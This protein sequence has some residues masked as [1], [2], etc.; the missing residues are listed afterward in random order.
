MQNSLSVP[1]YL[2]RMTTIRRVCGRVH[3]VRKRNRQNSLSM[4]VYAKNK[5]PEICRNLLPHASCELYVLAV[6]N[7]FKRQPRHVYTYG[8]VRNGSVIIQKINKK[9]KQQQRQA[10]GFEN[11]LAVATYLP[12]V[13]LAD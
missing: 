8:V 3:M 10:G 1:C 4:G 11:I 6:H 9:K 5:T 12:T 2:R 7:F 13:G